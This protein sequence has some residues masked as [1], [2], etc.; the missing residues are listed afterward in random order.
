M[1]YWLGYK[2]TWLPCY[3]ATDDGWKGETFHK[4]CDSKGPTVTIVRVGSYIF[5][6]YANV[7]FGGMT[8]IHTRYKEG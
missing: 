3:R 7:A 2:R 5:G 6:G 4:L 1:K 8:N